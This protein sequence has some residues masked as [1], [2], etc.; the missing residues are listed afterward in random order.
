MGD[1]ISLRTMRAFEEGLP[2]TSTRLDQSIDSEM[3]IVTS[4]REWPPSLRRFDRARSRHAFVGKRYHA[5]SYI[6]QGKV[7]VVGS[8][9]FTYPDLHDNVELNVPVGSEVH[10][11][12]A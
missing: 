2:Q 7:S 6:T 4:C 11:R 3:A 5:E 12:Q 10:E 8:S 1:K 9:S